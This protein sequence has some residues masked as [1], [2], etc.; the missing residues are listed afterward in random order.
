M[1]K[2]RLTKSVIRVI[3]QCLA[4]AGP[5]EQ[6]GA[7]SSLPVSAGSLHKIRHRLLEPYLSARARGS[8]LTDHELD[9]FMYGATEAE[10]A[11]PRFDINR[12]NDAM[13]GGLN[14]QHAVELASVLELG[15]VPRYSWLSEQYLQWKQSL[16]KDDLRLQPAGELCVVGSIETPL[17]LAKA[18]V[19]DHGQAYGIFVA[20]LP[21]SEFCYFAL[22]PSGCQLSWLSCFVEA[23]E[24][25]GGVPTHIDVTS[26]FC[27][28]RMY[29]GL[30]EH[31]GLKLTARRD[32][33]KMLMPKGENVRAQCIDWLHAHASRLLSAADVPTAN[34]VLTGLNSLWNGTNRLEGSREYSANAFCQLDAQCLRSLPRESYTPSKMATVHSDDNHVEYRGSYYSVPHWLAGEEV[35]LQR[36]D[37][38]LVIWLNDE[39]VADHSLVPKRR[40]FV[41]DPDH[42][43]TRWGLAQRI[44]KIANKF[45]D[46]GADAVR[47]F[48]MALEAEPEYV[49]R[50]FR[51]CRQVL[52]FRSRYSSQRVN[53]ALKKAVAAGACWYRQVK[54]LLV[55]QGKHRDMAVVGVREAFTI[56]RNSPS[57]SVATAPRLSTF[58]PMKQP[59]NST[60][61]PDIAGCLA[62]SADWVY[63]RISHVM[64]AGSTE[65]LSTLVVA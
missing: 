28:R 56:D 53:T 42:R 12:L 6:G 13:R 10:R 22:Y 19:K 50:A 59:S 64:A 7:A 41:T 30:C 43:P 37:T 62:K 32:T 40:V 1:P 49:E 27:D 2:P 11:R 31:Y 18:G 57:E 65:A 55:R 29:D 52:G 21:V 47:W 8:E 58:V 5:S 4:G 17:Q 44:E 24:Y 26:P 16:P 23:F 33:P 15:N 54:R 48:R 60:I 46:I 45:Y 3:L 34:N 63:K 35:Y 38:R 25:F 14:R 20:C 61:V 36:A 39:V 9:T 51:T